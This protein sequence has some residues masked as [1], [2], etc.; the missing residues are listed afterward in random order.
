MSLDSPQ[1]V[2]AEIKSPPMGDGRRFCFLK[3]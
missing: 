1:L 3:D 2:F